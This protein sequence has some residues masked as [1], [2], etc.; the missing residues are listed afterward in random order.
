[1][2]Y[3]YYANGAVVEKRGKGVF[4]AKRVLLFSAFLQILSRNIHRSLK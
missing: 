2:D 1:M 3:Y 4:R